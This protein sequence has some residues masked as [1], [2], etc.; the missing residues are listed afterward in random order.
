M[1]LASFLGTS[2]CVLYQFLVASHPHSIQ[3]KEIAPFQK[4]N[5][6]LV[7]ATIPQHKLLW[8]W[9]RYINTVRANVG[10]SNCMGY[11]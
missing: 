1:I 8:T 11:R 10:V 9:Q 7:E 4:S 3:T 2:L 6:T 5:L